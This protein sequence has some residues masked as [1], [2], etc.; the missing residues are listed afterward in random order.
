M[1]KIIPFF[2]FIIF[3]S[4]AQSYQNITP[5][6]VHERLVRGDTLLLVDVRETYEYTSGHIAEPEG[7]LPLTPALMPWSSSALSQH[8]HRLP[9]NID[10]IIYCRSGGRGAAASSFLESKGFTRIFNM[11]GGFNAWSFETRNN[12]FG[13]H[14]GRW[15]SHTSQDSTTINCF[16]SGDTSKLTFPPAQF[17]IVDSFYVELHLASPFRLVP[18]GIPES[19]VEG[20]F[21]VTILDQF[22]LSLFDGDSV[23]LSDTV[24]ISLFPNYKYNKDPVSLSDSKMTI[25][26]PGE[27]WRIIPYIYHN[28][29]FI[30]DDTILRKWYNVEGYIS[31]GVSNFTQIKEPILHAYP[32]PFNSFIQIVAPN[33]ALIYIYNQKGQLVDKLKSNIWRPDQ[34]LSSG[35]YFM[36]VLTKGKKIDRKILYL[37]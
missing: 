24:K 22:G 6:Q 31:T 14:S 25:Y 11:T 27:G 8:Y 16:T 26:V 12:G 19:A 29:L 15:I 34:T 1:K 28:F 17:S 23:I 33:D 36:N 9:R 2:T 18:P 3:T 10:I 37:K 35:L 32:N 20:T 5:A 30:A 21:R 4:A 7:Q 13:D